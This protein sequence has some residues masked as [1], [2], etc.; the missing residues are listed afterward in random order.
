M[1]TDLS[2]TEYQENIQ[3]NSLICKDERQFQMNDVKNM[4]DKI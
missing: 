2:Q 1:N 3:K 4:Q